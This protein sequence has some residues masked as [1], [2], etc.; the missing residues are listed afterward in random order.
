M[1]QTVMSKLL[2]QP[3]VSRFPMNPDH[4]FLHSKSSF[5]FLLQVIHFSKCSH[6][7]NRGAVPGHPGVDHLLQHASVSRVLSALDLRRM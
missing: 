1:G 2:F 4:L 5:L 6:F 7:T 3:P